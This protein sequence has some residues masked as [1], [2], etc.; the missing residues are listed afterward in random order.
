[1][2][3]DGAEGEGGVVAGVFIALSASAWPVLVSASAA[4]HTTTQPVARSRFFADMLPSGFLARLAGSPPARRPSLATIHPKGQKRA[5][6]R[7]V[8]DVMRNDN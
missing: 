4:A 6:A 1:M 2:D 5:A 3:L 7:R 8:N